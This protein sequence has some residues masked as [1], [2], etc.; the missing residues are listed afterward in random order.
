MK[1]IFLIFLCSAQ[2]LHWKQILTFF[3]D[4]D[5]QNIIL[6]IKWSYQKFVFLFTKIGVVNWYSS[7]KIV[8]SRKI[9][10]IFDIEYDFES[11]NFAFFRVYL[12]CQ[13]NQKKINA[14]F[15]TCTV[16]KGAF[17]KIPFRWIYYYGSNK[18]TGKE[19]GKTHLCTVEY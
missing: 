1:L 2:K 10:I 11:Q 17:C 7:M 4:F 6:E 5:L 12:I 16:Y 9:R 8:F 3:I 13:K 18:S 15:V 14:I 19:T